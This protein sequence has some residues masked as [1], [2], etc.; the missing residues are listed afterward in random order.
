MKETNSRISRTGGGALKFVLALTLALGMAPAMPTA[1]ASEE[2]ATDAGAPSV[3]TG[4]SESVVELGEETSRYELRDALQGANGGTVKL[5]ANLSFDEF[6][7]SITLSN[8]NATL[9]LNGHTITFG[10][11]TFNIKVQKTS[12]IT[13]VDTSKEGGGSIV[14][15]G[16]I[17][18]SW[19]IECVGTLTIKGGTVSGPNAA[20]KANGESARFTMTG[21]ELKGGDTA[22][23][24]T[25]GAAA[26]IEGGSVTSTGA[27]GT[28]VR[29]EGAEA[30]VSGN[31]VLK[32][33]YGVVLFN[34][35][36]NKEGTA[37]SVLTVDGGSIEAEYFAISGNNK[38][39]AGCSA[40]IKSGTVSSFK[41]A[42]IYWP[43]EG[44]L[45]I[46]GGY[47]S[48]ATVVEAKMGTIE[49]SGGTLTATGGKSSANIGGFSISDG[50]VVKVVGQSYGSSEGQYIENPDLSVSITDGT[51]V[52]EKGNAVTVYNDGVGTDSSAEKPECTV[53]VSDEATLAPAQDCDAV[54]VVS[55]VEEFTVDQTAGTVSNGNT[56]IKSSALAGSAVLVTTKTVSSIDGSQKDDTTT[57]C[58]GVGRAISE[59]KGVESPT[60]TLLSDISE[61]VVVPEGGSVTINFNSHTLTGSIVNAGT[62][63]LKGEGK[64]V[65]QV[66]DI[67]GSTTVAGNISMAV[68]QI[69]EKTYATLGEAIDKAVSGDTIE[70]LGDVYCPPFAIPA[71]V[72]LDGDGH[73]ITC[74]TR[75]DNGAFITA[76]TGADNVTIEDVTIDVGGK[77]KHGVQFYCNE[78]GVLDDVT[79]KG[80]YW[81]AVQ[82]NGAKGVTIDG[83]TLDP[84]AAE[85]DGAA[86]S[87]YAFIEFS[88]GGGVTS[89]PS[90]TV[91]DVDFG[92]ADCPMVWVDDETVARIKDALKLDGATDSEV[93]G[94][95]KEQITNSSHSDL[96]ISIEL[97]AGD[98][99]D[100]EIGGV[101]VTPPA[102]PSYDVTVDQP[103]NGTVELSSATAKEG[104]KVTITVKPD[105]GFELA[106]L[107]VAD[108]DGNALKLE[109]NA[110][111]TYSFEMPAGDVTVHAAFECDGGE[112][113]P[114]HSFTD[115]DQDKWYHDAIDWAVENR[116]LN[117]I[118]GTTLMMPDGKTTRA[119]MAQVLWN[120]EGRPAAT[121]EEA[122]SDVEE[123]DWFYGAASWAAQEGIFEGY[124]G[125]FDPDAVLTREQAAAVL[126]RWTEM[127]GGDV[128]GRADLSKFPDA[129]SVSGWAVDSVKWAVESGVLQGVENSGVT[130][131]DAQGTATRAQVAALM[132]RLEA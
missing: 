34:S 84:Q 107:V 106:S 110:D 5:T 16:A 26:A 58:S 50:S 101:P 3:S 125:K 24:G 19:V 68:A 57:L 80:S 25:G 76:S 73:T 115:V 120:V 130:T 43:M 48:G 32:G 109:L 91:G 56:T 63:E 126:M 35:D 86:K 70:L 79:V 22:L 52:S 99:V 10:A 41:E 12:A 28:A 111:G 59:A 2:A 87:P 78:G 132:M 13:I 39:S 54:R 20:V 6:G 114:S 124:D 77:M 92:D 60:V 123:G 46:A 93:I 119:E 81:T 108:E 31:S 83:C 14:Q 102:K 64:L 116:V 53:L 29:L 1:F 75:N 89:V 69:G 121:D 72:T 95:I 27:N 97:V 42:A 44:E 18:D 104:Q 30:T 47:L 71:G 65:G 38:K 45:A 85:V 37:H 74:S 122:F 9:D 66:Q 55:E 100:D 88:M 96:G 33:V 98:P 105:A 90:M 8:A 67:G 118:G 51:L 61:D 4:S 112:L 36:E 131:I 128:S 129:G 21:G 11:S 40:A 82:V 15:S 7:A 103:A 62:L 117:G 23:I 94:A 49:I 127:N 17:D 113:C